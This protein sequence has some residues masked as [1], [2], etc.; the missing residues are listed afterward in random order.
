M[1]VK[2]VAASACWVLPPAGDGASGLSWAPHI[3]D[4]SDVKKKIQR[5]D[6]I[7]IPNSMQEPRLII[8]PDDELA[9]RPIRPGAVRP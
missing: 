3:C 4:F 9:A 1:A 7:H 6:G 5:I 2:L 8:K